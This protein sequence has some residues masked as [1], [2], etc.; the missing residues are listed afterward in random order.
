MLIE[1]MPIVLFIKSRIRDPKIVS[2]THEWRIE[3]SLIDTILIKH[4]EDM[5][6]Y[7]VEPYME[8]ICFEKMILFLNDSPE[9][10][11]HLRKADELEARRRKDR[12]T[13]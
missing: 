5:G 12:H 9:I 7:S 6:I 11:K 2:I 13:D 1:S 3:P 8:K 4:F 10:Y